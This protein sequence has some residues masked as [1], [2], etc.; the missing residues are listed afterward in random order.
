MIFNPG[1]FEGLGAF[2]RLIRYSD[3]REYSGIG[4]KAEYA[5]NDLVKWNDLG[6]Q[7]L[8]GKFSK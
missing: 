3:S 7:V 6:Y 2:F 5:E 4:L 8:S 1:P